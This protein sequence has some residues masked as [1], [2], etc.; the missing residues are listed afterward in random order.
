MK[1]PTVLEG[2]EYR[3]S[4]LET[5]GNTPLV[6]LRVVARDCPATVLA[7]L[8]F[9]NPGGS[10]KDRI[11]LAMVEA[12]ERDGRLKSGGTIVERY[13]DISKPAIASLLMISTSEPSAVSPSTTPL[14]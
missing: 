13:L 1:N 9:F 7:K 10:V 3:E 2:L 4:V 12:A 14:M 5:V 11:G 8:E 6:R